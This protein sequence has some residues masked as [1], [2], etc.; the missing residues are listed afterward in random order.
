MT[1]SGT[2]DTGVAGFINVPCNTMF[3]VG[4]DDKHYIIT[5]SRAA[6]AQSDPDPLSIGQ[7]EDK[8]VQT[9]DATQWRADLVATGVASG[10][11]GTFY[12]CC[13]P[14]PCPGTPYFYWLGY[15]HGARSDSALP[16]GRFYAVGVRYKIDSGGAPAVDGGFL[17]LGTDTPVPYYGTPFPGQC[18]GAIVKSGFV[19]AACNMGAF[20][21]DD[22]GVFLAKLPLSGSPSDPLTPGSWNDLITFVTTDL[23]GG[24]AGGSNFYFSNAGTAAFD[25]AAIIPQPDGSFNV[26]SYLPWNVIENVQ[27]G[28][29]WHNIDT[30]GSE[31]WNVNPLSQISSSTPR[32]YRGDFDQPWADSKTLY[33]G[34]ASSNIRDDYSAPS[35]QA[36]SGGY[37]ITFTRTFSDQPTKLRIRRYFCDGTTGAISYVDTFEKTIPGVTPVQDFGMFYRESDGDVIYALS[38][39]SVWYFG[40]DSTP[41]SPESGSCCEDPVIVDQDIVDLLSQRALRCAYLV[42]F[43][44]LTTPQYLWNGHYTLEG[45]GGHDWSGLRN[46]GGIEGLEEAADMTAQQ[47]KFTLS[48]V[49][50][51]TLALAVGED[52]DEYVGR[53]VTVW[54]QFFDAN[55][56]PKGN[57]I[58]RSAGIM[59]GIEITRSR[60]GDQDKQNS[61]RVLTLTAET[62]WYGRGIPPAGNYTSRDQKIRSEGDRGLDFV[63]EVQNTVV[64]VP[65]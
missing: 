22:Y 28:V 42:Q 1:I 43:D 38:S 41:R 32:D 55:W 27:T 19:Y 46:L 26:T 64:Q 40:E 53:L 25:T 34:G 12:P 60:D 61:V 10:I 48:G 30:T 33:S 31:Y 20:T 23:N 49:D 63:N 6:T 65:W 54:L 39:S 37:E 7:A 18:Y 9:I 44:F 62:I 8:S 15:Q 5:A 47:M 17:Y 24:S 16:S 13:S 29:T 36:V 3:V 4:E 52:R 57:P 50:A 14:I 2:L 58:A 11:T 51:A 59:D 45:I 56:Q 35:V 21:F